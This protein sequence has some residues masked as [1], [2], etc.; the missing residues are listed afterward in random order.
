MP[1]S[2]PVTSSALG[3]GLVRLGGGG[4]GGSGGD[5]G[6]GGEGGGGGSGGGGEGGEGGGGGGRGEAALTMASSGTVAAATAA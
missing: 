2:L 3:S 1:P 6:G 4:M 5:E